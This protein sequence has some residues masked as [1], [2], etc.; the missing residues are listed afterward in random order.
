MRSVD[1]A[2]TL[3]HDLTEPSLDPFPNEVD[4]ARWDEACRRAEAIRG[5]L[6]SQSGKVVAGDV[7]LLAAELDVS[8]A[9][10]CRRASPQVLRRQPS[11][12]ILISQAHLLLGRT[13]TCR[14]DL[15]IRGSVPSIWLSWCGSVDNECPGDGDHTNGYD[16]VRRPSR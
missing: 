15:E 3:S 13:H 10:A 14:T 12:E 4:E 8:R 6:L 7:A 9:T 2:A 11:V 16:R 5:F 1:N